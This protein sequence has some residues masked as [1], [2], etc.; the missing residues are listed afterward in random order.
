MR[1]NGLDTLRAIAIVG[2]VVCHIC[3]QLGY[4]PMGRVTGFLFVQQLSYAADFSLPICFIILLSGAVASARVYLKA[5]TLMQTLAGYLT[6]FSF[7]F[8]A[9]II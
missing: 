7:I 2:I 8:I 5:H 3:L 6:G 1:H 9:G 4:E